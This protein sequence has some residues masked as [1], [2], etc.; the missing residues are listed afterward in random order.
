MGTDDAASGLYDL[1]RS[2]NAKEGLKDIGFTEADIDK[3]A[4]I[5]TQN[6]YANPAPVTKEG[7]VKLLTDA[8][9]GVRL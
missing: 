7:V 1:N 8:Y 4:N 9:H 3:A 2:I 6:P 5:A